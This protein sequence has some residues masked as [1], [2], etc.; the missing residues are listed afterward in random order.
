[1]SINLDFWQPRSVTH[2]HN[3]CKIRA[4]KK[5]KPVKVKCGISFHSIGLNQQ[6]P[7]STVEKLKFEK[8]RETP[9]SVLQNTCPHFAGTDTTAMAKKASSA[10]DVWT[11]LLDVYHTKH[12]QARTALTKA[13]ISFLIEERKTQCRLRHDY[14]II[15]NIVK[16]VCMH[17]QNM[18]EIR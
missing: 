10:D 14:D 11:N 18:K 13:D 7:L 12:Q 1:M 5:K 8:I 2:N 15:S 9:P 17:S 3:F 16:D 4:R 6:Y